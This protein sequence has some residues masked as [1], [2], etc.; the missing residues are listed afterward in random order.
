M[1]SALGFLPSQ[2]RERD[3]SNEGKNGHANDS[4]DGSFHGRYS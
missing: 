4:L 2:K 1:G 3:K